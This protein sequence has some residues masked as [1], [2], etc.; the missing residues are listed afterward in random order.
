MN[1]YFIF[2]KGDYLNG[3]VL[4][5]PPVYGNTYIAQKFHGEKSVSQEAFHG[6]R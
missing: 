6:F 1:K 2:S 4:Y 5:G 3:M